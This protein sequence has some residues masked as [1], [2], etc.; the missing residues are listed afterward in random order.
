MQYPGVNSSLPSRLFCRQ[1]F[2]DESLGRTTMI[3]LKKPA[4]ARLQSLVD[5][6][7]GLDFSYQAV[8]S[9]AAEI[10][11]GY[12]VDRLRIQLGQ[13][14]AV[15]EKAR[16]ALQ[17]WEHFSLGW[18]EILWPSAP[19]QPGQTGVMLA[20]SLGM[21][22]G[23]VCRIVYVVDERGPTTRFG[24]AYGTLPHHVEEGEERFLIEKDETG[25]VWYEILAF[26]RPHH[27]LAWVGYPYVRLLQRR[28]RTESAAAMLRV[29]SSIK[30]KP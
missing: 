25:G 11:P 18:V 20:H 9:T 15:F 8:G 24:F 7:A 26:S 16:E 5:S 13:G 17:R 2:S 27:V 3:S 12:Q 28:F 6:Q 1:D 21:W 4:A 29:V 30:K 22:W 23:N 14:D 10:P 19:L